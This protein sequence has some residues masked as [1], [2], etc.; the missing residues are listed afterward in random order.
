MN[1]CPHCNAPVNPL[2]LLFRSRYYRCG[3]C[4]GLA[5]I[6]GKQDLVI[7]AAYSAVI[8]PFILLSPHDWTIW[9]GVALYLMLTIANAAAVYLFVR[10]EAAETRDSR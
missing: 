10:F 9:T 6:P 1:T 2:R 7:P 4:R 5:C 8:F 3:H